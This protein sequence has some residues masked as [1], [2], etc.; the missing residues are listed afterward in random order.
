MTAPLDLAALRAL[1]EQATPLPWAHDRSGVFHVE[2]LG[3]IL[4]EDRTRKGN[5]VG[6]GRVGDTYPRG[7]NH[8][9]ENMALIAAAVN[10]LPALLDELEGLRADA[11]RLDWL[12]SIIEPDTRIEINHYAVNEHK[13][14]GDYVH[15]GKLIDIEDR[16]SDGTH[17][18]GNSLREA[19]D[20]ARGE[21]R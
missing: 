13:V 8:P 7:D 15:I 10:A 1:V 21:G 3:P 17:G 18:D 5:A 2:S 16:I 12:Q 6:I 19:L 14:R 4:D 20:R 9:T 11:A